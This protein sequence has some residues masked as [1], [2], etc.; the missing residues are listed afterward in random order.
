MQGQGQSGKGA[1][2]S[3]TVGV[4]PAARALAE[5]LLPNGDERAVRAV[6]EVLPDRDSWGNNAVTALQ[7]AAESAREAAAVIDADGGTGAD[8]GAGAGG[9]ADSVLQ[10]LVGAARED[11]PRGKTSHE[12]TCPADAGLVQFGVGY[13]TAVQLVAAHQASTAVLEQLLQDSRDALAGLAASMG[14]C[15]GQPDYDSVDVLLDARRLCSAVLEAHAQS[16]VVLAK[17][18]RELRLGRELRE[19]ED[20]LGGRERERRA[21]QDR[22]GRAAEEMAV[23]TAGSAAGETGNRR[24]HGPRRGTAPPSTRTASGGSGGGRGTGTGSD[25]P[26]SPELLARFAAVTARQPSRRGTQARK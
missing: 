22:A 25:H 8:A 14:H 15:L 23:A 2:E 20:L 21:E 24:S 5:A 17:R 19:A 4:L 1:A 10:G 18:G 26:F 12:S 16:R 3:S 7:W 6:L 9:R 13:G 11:V